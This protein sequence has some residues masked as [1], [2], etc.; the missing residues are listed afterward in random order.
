MAVDEL[1]LPTLTALAGVMKSVVESA[2]SGATWRGATMQHL[3]GTVSISS[4]LN[5]DWVEHKTII[6]PLKRL[7][8]S[9]D[10][11]AVLISKDWSLSQR[12]YQLQLVT[13]LAISFASAESSLR[14]CF[15]KMAANSSTT[16]SVQWHYQRQ[17]A[18]ETARFQF[19]QSSV[20][21]LSWHCQVNMQLPA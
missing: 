21:Y 18:C 19:P 7:K 8:I 13:Y 11:R 5:K 17:E 4:L 6:E 20:S 2:N 15:V 14:G 12:L 3:V 10:K 1:L 9:R 16:G